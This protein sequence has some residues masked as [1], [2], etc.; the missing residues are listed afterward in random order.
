ME[1]SL[2]TCKQRNNARYLLRLLVSAAITAVFLLIILVNLEYISYYYRG[3]VTNMFSRLIVRF[4]LGEK[5]AFLCM[6]SMI[7]VP[8]GLL[9]ILFTLLFWAGSMKSKFVT[10]VLAQVPGAAKRDIPGLFAEIDEDVQTSRYR[11]GQNVIGD[12]WILVQCSFTE[13][14]VMKRENLKGFY[15]DRKGNNGKRFLTLV[16]N[17]FHVIKFTASIETL[18]MIY[19]D[20]TRLHPELPCGTTYQEYLQVQK[21]N[22]ARQEAAH[23]GESR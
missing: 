7:I 23:L 11:Y 8:L 15:I 5:K 17:G 16:G 18:K 21:N 2:K 13:P 12:K 19:S 22:R 9:K 3:T 4:D 6:L 10:S 20:L 14:R 1:K